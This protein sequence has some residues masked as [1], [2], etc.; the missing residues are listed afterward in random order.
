[1]IEWLRK[2]LGASGLF[3]AAWYCASYGD[4][5]LS[6]MDPLE[7]LLRVGIWLG[8]DPGP[9]FSALF[10]RLASSDV[11]DASEVALLRYLQH[12]HLP[13]QPSRVMLAATALA[14]SGRPNDAIYLARIHLGSGAD[15]TLRL[16]HA[17]QAVDEGDAAGW[18]HRLNDYLGPYE[19]APVTLGEDG[20][21]LHRLGTASLRQVTGGPKVSIIM[22]VHDGAMTVEAAA[23]SILGQTWSNLELLI[24]DDASSDDSWRRMQALARSDSR[25]RIRRNPKNVGP[26]VNRNL[27]MREATGEWITCHD[28]DDWAHPQ[29]IEKHLGAMLESQGAILA[30]TNY[31]LRMSSSGRFENVIEASAHHAPDGF[32]RR[33]FASCLFHRPTLEQKLGYWDP[34]RFASDG[35]MLHRAQKVLGEAWRDFDLF[36]ML[37]LDLSAGLTNDPRHGLNTASGISDSRQQYNA[38]WQDWHRHADSSALRLDFPVAVRPFPMPEVMAVPAADIAVCIAARAPV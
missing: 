30:G 8:R 17:N 3:D 36:A 38:A 33:A 24:I 4:V 10:Y 15:R 11:A 25:V 21:L 37:C 29:R 9:R 6:G 20:P 23:R 2:A 26:Y 12:G 13:V 34:V 16:F 35:E 18:L 19:I 32:R 7:H 28:A 27:A 31:M 14:R 5:T 1:M 22:S